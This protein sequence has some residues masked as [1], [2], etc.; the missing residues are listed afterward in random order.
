MNSANVVMNRPAV[1]VGLSVFQ[2]GGDFAD[3][4]IAYEGEWLGAE[5]FVS[6]DVK[7]A[8]VLQSQGTRAFLPIATTH[9]VTGSE[10]PTSKSKQR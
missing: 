6:F 7:A 4:V 8:S 10:P 2:A 9:Q 3:G 1:E 5:E